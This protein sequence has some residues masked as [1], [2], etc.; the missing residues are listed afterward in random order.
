MTEL[1]A[2][3]SSLS[4]TVSPRPYAP[5]WFDRFSAWVDR[6][7][8]PAPVFYLGLGVALVIL[9]GLIQFSQPSHQVYAFPLVY[10]V[11]L[12]YHLALMHYLDQVAAYALAR[13]RSLLTVSDAE[14]DSLLYRLTTLPARPVWV[15][16]AI[17]FLY[18]LSVFIWLPYSAQVNELHFADTPLSS[19][20]NRAFAPLIF[21]VLGTVIYH[22]IHQ[23]N[24]VRRI[25]ERHIRVDVFVLRPLYSFSS[26]SALTAV[27]IGLISYLWFLTTPTLMLPNMLFFV[28]LTSIALLTFILPLR[29]AHQ[30]LEA[31][32]D[33][34]L[35][36]NGERQR[37]I[38]AELHRRV[39]SL[40]MSG[41]DD[42][43]KTLSGLELEHKMLDGISTWPWNPGTP[44][45]VAAALLLPIV[46]WL[47]QWLLERALTPP[48]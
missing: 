19:G 22:A 24:I 27:G 42:V 31:E 1:S 25:Y 34:L 26:L 9:Q 21:F 44:R 30:L 37:I 6:L 8:V 2:S 38:I 40:D 35:G 41:I 3:P 46:L 16:G 32:K 45:A 15:A 7:P 14:Y 12:A 48:V 39:D 18:G 11:S 28:G 36:E 47:A 4:P 20:F 29:G 17:G 13:F 10:V 33:R 43:H 5:S 23:L